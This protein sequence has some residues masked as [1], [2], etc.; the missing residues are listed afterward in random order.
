MCSCKQQL[1]EAHNKANISFKK[2]F[3]KKCAQTLVY[4][5]DINKQYCTFKPS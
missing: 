5:I 1:H 4:I 3:Y 2:P